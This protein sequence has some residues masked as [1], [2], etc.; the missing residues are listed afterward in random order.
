MNDLVLKILSLFMLLGTCV[1]SAQD[2]EKHTWTLGYKP[3]KVIPFQ[4]APGVKL[5]LHAFFPKDHTAADKRATVVFFFG[6]GWMG[7]SPNQ[8]YG[9]AKYF[10]SRGMVA[11]SAQYRTQRS[12]NVEPKVAVQDAREALRYIRQHAVELGVDPTKLAVGGGSAGGHVAAATLMCP[13]LDISP[14]NATNTLPN[15]LILFNPVFDNG[16]GG[17]G[18]ERVTD[19]WQDISP[20]HN[21]K[22][23]F[24]PSISFFGDSDKHVPIATIKKFEEKMH[25]A[26]NIFESHIYPGEQHGFFHISKGGRKVFEDVMIKTDDF[27]VRHGFLSGS[28]QVKEWTAKSIELLK[29][30]ELLKKR[31]NEA[32]K[33]AKNKKQ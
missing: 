28:P 17:Y 16:P 1:A 8:F 27:L 18:H 13:K 14:D 24:G 25:S 2:R 23:G 11:I 29:P 30:I 26:G 9:M 5:A 32:K 15:A 3:D 19:Y 31:R 4:A 33:E 7:G 21:I 12:H 22:S 6:G 20:M 10:A